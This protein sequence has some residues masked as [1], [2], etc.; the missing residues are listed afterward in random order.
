MIILDKV[1]KKYGDKAV[2]DGLSLCLPD[3]RNIAICGPSGSGKS[4]LLSIL[5]GTEKTDSGKIVPEV[6]SLGVSMSFQ[7]PRLLPGRTAAENVNLVMGDRPATLPDARKILCELGI[8]DTEKYPEQLSGGMKARVGIARAL[9]VKRRVYLFDEPFA[10]LD[11][12]N[13]MRTAEVIQRHTAGALTIM[14]IHDK[15][16]ARRIS[17]TLIVFNDEILNGNFTVEGVTADR[18]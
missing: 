17:D 12:E 15:D 1:T 3:N 2:I 7:D 10:A 9:A 4:T 18:L 5:A 6:T 14:V 16:L 8:C 11:E 13:I